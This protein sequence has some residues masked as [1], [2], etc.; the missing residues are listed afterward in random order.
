MRTRIFAVLAMPFALSGC[1]TWGSFNERLTN[2]GGNSID[3][4]IDRL[5]YPSDE[6]TIAGRH[7]FTWSTSSSGVVFMP[8]TSYSTATAYNRFGTTTATGT[9]TSYAPMPVSYGCQVILEVDGNNRITRYQY[10]GNIGGCQG[11]WRRL[12]GVTPASPTFTFRSNP[13]YLLNKY[14]TDKKE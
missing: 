5:G 6:R 11:Y 12:E 10:S 3:V 14:S 2:L 7:L 8:Q 1:M 13:Q 4:A 9:T